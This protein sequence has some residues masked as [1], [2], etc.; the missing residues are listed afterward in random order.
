MYR[1]KKENSKRVFVSGMGCVNSIAESAAEFEQA[2]R[3]GRQGIDFYKESKQKGPIKIGA[4]IRNFSLN[5]RID[6]YS[7]KENV[8][9]TILN[10]ARKV[11]RRSPF[12]IQTAVAAVLEAY[13]Q[14]DLFQKQVSGERIG[15]IVAGNNLTNVVKNAYMDKC[16]NDLEYMSPSYA[17]QFMDTDH[18]GTLSEIFGIFGEGCTIGGASASGNVGIIKAYEMLQLEIADICIVVG[19]MAELSDA[20]MYGFYNVGALGGRRFGTEPQKACRPFDMEHEGFIYGQ[21]CGCF[22]LESQES[23]AKRNAGILAEIM[24]GAILLDGNRLSNPSVQGEARV[25]ELVLDRCGLV[26]ED[27]DYIN[28]HGTSSPLGDET[29]LKA[30]KQVWK[31]QVKNVWINSTKG[32]IGHCFYAAGVMEAIASIIQMKEGFLHP[33]KNLDHPISKGFRFV[34]NDREEKQIDIAMSNSFGFGG[35][36]TSIVLKYCSQYKSE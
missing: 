34:G 15:I 20:E 13:V 35:I 3:E 23:I 18:I 11:A 27:I 33:N 30:I 4:E 5:K 25:M 16:K 10:K 26:P 7:L 24:G 19:A 29:E 17:L 21:G 14:A 31:D 1:L 12:V 32:L 28:T 22:I 2:L 6:D 36:N 9:Q 8:P